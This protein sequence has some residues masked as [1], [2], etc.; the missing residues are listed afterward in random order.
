MGGDS[1]R[2]RPQI[3]IARHITAQKN[4]IMIIG[5]DG[6]RA[7][8]NFTGLGNYS[9]FIISA[10]NRNYPDNTY[11]V[12]SPKAKESSELS[13][14]LHENTHL[15]LPRHFIDK[16]LSSLWRTKRIVAD[17]KEKGVEL[18]HG[19]SNEI[20]AGIEESGIKSV[21]TI[22]DLIFLRYPEYY[23]P[24]DRKIYDRKFRSASERSDRI[25][26]VSECTKRDIVSFYGI[27]PEKIDVVY[28]GFHPIFS[29]AP[30]ESEKR[31]IAE[32]YALPKRFI[33]CVGTIEE[34]KNLMLPAEALRSLP[35]DIHLVAAGR[36][37][38]YAEKVEKY[39]SEK[40]L[41][42]RLHII[43]GVPFRLLPA[44]YS[45]ASVF[46]YPSRFEGFGIPII[47][48]LQTGIPVLAATGSC[49]E[50]AG[51]DGALYVN[52]DDTEAAA[53]ALERL[54]YDADLTARLKAAGKEQIRKFSPENI[55]NGV[56]E[57]Y[58]KI[59]G[60]SL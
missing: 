5:F 12:F 10:L 38:P 42:K 21:V 31:E 8:L 30:G 54:L 25:I 4:N 43:E 32:M 56:N 39:C 24:I 52:P 37:T 34:R 44:L 1:R 18:Y 3:R 11:E 26:A 14:M 9:R 51:G 19:L 17:L 6:K 46:A 20:P 58:R 2:L 47:E 15:N 16:R 27:P 41:S 29:T 60:K 45:L 36:R 35:E 59:T 48:A 50:E 55:A 22:H 49:L 28:Q 57:V 40:G 33:L 7:V 53:D 23:K 13:S